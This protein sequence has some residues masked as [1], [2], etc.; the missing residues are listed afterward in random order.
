MGTR[1]HPQF[2]SNFLL[3]DGMLI[4][5]AVITE[6]YL[7]EDRFNTLD[8]ETYKDS[9]FRVITGMLGHLELLIPIV[10]LSPC[11]RFRYPE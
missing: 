7:S 11:S 1:H 3:S 8:G 5:E 10:A 2:S 9:L 4:D 6:H